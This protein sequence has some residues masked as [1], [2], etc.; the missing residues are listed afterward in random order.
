MDLLR[1]TIAKVTK[2]FDVYFIE[3]NNKKILDFD[4]FNEV[5]YTAQSNVATYPIES[6]IAITDYKYNTPNI[7]NCVATVSD[8]NIVALVG[9]AILDKQTKEDI[10]KDKLNDLIIKLER[11]NIHTKRGF[12]QNYTL[13]KF[14]IIE[15]IEN[16]G[17]LK[18]EMTFQEA[19]FLADVLGNLN[20][21][22]SASDSNTQNAGI[23]KLN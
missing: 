5:D 2:F 1:N 18:V 10:I 13:T 21:L 9:F 17:H 6:N 8:K 16:Y 12:Y 20:N 4:T 23:T 14:Y 19:I 15:D 7:V 22:K 3:Q 11:V